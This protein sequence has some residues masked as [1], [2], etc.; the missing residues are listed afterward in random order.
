VGPLWLARMVGRLSM[1][2][3]KPCRLFSRGAELLRLS[4]E[5]PPSIF[6]PQLLAVWFPV[7]L[8]HITGLTLLGALA[9]IAFVG[10]SKIRG[11]EPRTGS[12]RTYKVFYVVARPLAYTGLGVVASI[13]VTQMEQS[14]QPQPRYLSGRPDAC[15]TFEW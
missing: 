9:Y 14:A 13:Y 15:T 10:N 3:I 12:R 5:C 2:C 1:P 6:Q 7:F 8:L 11:G 4:R